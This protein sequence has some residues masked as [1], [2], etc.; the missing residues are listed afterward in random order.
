LPPQKRLR[1]IRRGLS[2]PPPTPPALELLGDREAPGRP[3]HLLNL[4]CRV[5]G[6]ARGA[7]G[8]VSAEGDLVEHLSFG[9]PEDVATELARSAWSEGLVQAILRQPLPLNLP[10]FAQNPFG[11]ALPPTPPALGPFLGVPLFFHG[12]PRGAL[13]LARLPGQPAFDA[14]DQETV[15]PICAWLELGNLVEET[16]VQAQLR[17]LNRVAQAAAGS[18]DLPR[19]L[20]VALRE[21]ERYLPWHTSVVWLLEESA[22]TG[23]TNQQGSTLVLAH[24]DARPKDRAEKLGL[25]P[26]R[27]IDVTQ[28]PFALCL[29][30]GDALY[31][32]LRQ[33]EE[34]GSL[35]QDLV[36]RGANS[37]CAVPLRAGERTLGLLHSVCTRA[38]GFDHEQIQFLY[39]VADLLGPA[40]SNCQLYGRLRTAYEDLR[41]TQEQLIQA[42]KMRAL[43]ELAGGMAHDFN[44]SLCGVM[45]F[46]DLSLA[47][48][49]VAPRI[50]GYL[51]SAL[52]CS[53]DAAHTVRRVQSFARWRRNE[54]EVQRIDVNDLVRQTIELT[55]HK[56]ESLTHA[57]GTPITVEVRTGAASWVTGSGSE[58]R[59]VLTNLVFNAVDAMPQGGRLT[60]STWSTATDSFLS[61]RDTGVGMSATVRQRL[62]EPFFTTKGERGTG[63][64]L[65]VTFG[66]IQRYGGAIEVESEVGLGSTFTIRLPSTPREAIPAS[67]LVSGT[68]PA[69][70]AGSALGAGL[71]TPPPLERKSLRVLVIEDEESV[72]RFLDTGLTQLGHRPHLQEDAEQGLAAFAREPFDVVLTDLGLPGA[73]GEEVARTVSRTAPGTP[74]VLL[75]GWSDQLKEESQVLEGVTRILGKPITLKALDATLTAVCGSDQASANVLCG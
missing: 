34:N 37:H 61:V 64:G 15:L 73:S 12:R 54:L 56:W 23:T 5:L 29:Q 4:V 2:V 33:P 16:R 13:Y 21:L 72:R 63:L 6:A 42:E 60:V 32:D 51:Q 8:L 41:Q 74:V 38:S 43:G 18:L 11:L 47:D 55:R 30:G 10:D 36:V 3:Q 66:I 25:T 22:A 44:N 52:T 35:V 48:P 58:L 71:P 70:G 9:V 24:T 19:I 65:S 1:E 14:H 27:R 45:G 75:T 7:I 53:Q 26:G 46:L 49:A 31:A 28:T 62:F 20:T 69:L 17:L 59:E 40:I 50:R 67:N 57:R 39:L 68:D